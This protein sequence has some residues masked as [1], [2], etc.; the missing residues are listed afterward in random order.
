M[1]KEKIT[2]RITEEVMGSPKQHVEETLDNVIIKLKELKDVTILNIQ[3]HDAKEMDNKM[4]SAFADIEFETQEMKKILEICFDFMPSN[5][6]ILEPAGVT[7]DSDDFTEMLNDL[8]AKQ[9]KYSF[10]LN[11]LK[12]ENIYMMKKLK[13]EIK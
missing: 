5:I 12:T 7:L 1:K 3:K 4:F 13:G 10:V 6:E 11:K 2:V 9:H 8:L